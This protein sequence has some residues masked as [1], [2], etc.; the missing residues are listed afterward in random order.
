MLRTGLLSTDSNHL[1]RLLRV[2]WVDSRPIDYLQWSLVA[3]VPVGDML[4]SPDSALVRP[5]MGKALDVVLVADSLALDVKVA[6][7]TA[8][9]TAAAVGI[10][11]AQAR[12]SAS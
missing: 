8:T 9:A 11:A 5:S 3:V 6:A 1:H 12:G 2:G 7:H 4:G 10:A